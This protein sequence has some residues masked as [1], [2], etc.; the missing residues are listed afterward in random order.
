MP[1][2][3]LLQMSP[4]KANRFSRC[5]SSSSADGL[6]GSSLLLCC[7]MR[8]LL[9]CCLAASTPACRSTRMLAD[10]SDA[11]W[12][13]TGAAGLRRGKGSDMATSAMCVSLMLSEAGSLLLWLR[14]SPELPL[15]WCALSS[16][17]ATGARSCTGGALPKHLKSVCCHGMLL[18]TA[19]S[20]A[21]AGPRTRSHSPLTGGLIG[22]KRRHEAQAARPGQ[23]DGSNVDNLRSSNP[24]LL[25]QGSLG[26]A[27][28]AAQQPRALS[29][30]NHTKSRCSKDASR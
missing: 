22:H 25:P 29:S 14:L 7:L 3:R 23:H 24:R 20:W 10:L 1:A 27:R 6:R 2:P 8:C 21:S 16:R 5:Q 12:P 15:C 17:R 13:P 9:A 30:L 4:T 18:A 26:L 28:P 19:I 11:S